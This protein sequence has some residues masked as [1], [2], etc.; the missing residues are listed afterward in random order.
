[1]SVSGTGYLELLYAFF[2]QLGVGYCRANSPAIRSVLGKSLQPSLHQACGARQGGIR[3]RR[4]Q[5]CLY[6]CSIMYAE[7]SQMCT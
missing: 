5:L 2:L 7:M 6:R 3:R 1:M 4:S